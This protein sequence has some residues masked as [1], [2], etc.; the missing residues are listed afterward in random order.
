MQTIAIAILKF[1]TMLFKKGLTYNF[2]N[3]AHS[4]LSSFVILDRG[5]TVGTHPLTSRFMKGVYTLRP[6]IPRY[7][8]TWDV[9]IVFDYL[10]KLAPADSLNLKNLTLKLV[11]LIALVSAQ[12]SQSIHKLSLD[13]MYYKG[14]TTNFQIT[15][16]IKQSKPGMGGLTV[17]LPAYPVDRRLCVLTYLKHYINRTRKLQGKDA[18]LFISF[19]K[20]HRPVS[21]DISRWINLVMKDSGV[22]VTCFKPHSTRAAAT[23][24]ADKL[25]VPISLIL[26]TAGWSNERTF[27][28]Y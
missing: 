15:S 7:E 11:M 24:A 1:L 20:P 19:K 8:Y 21:K 4:S 14:S 16:L 28:Q 9:H 27:R 5:N 3:V 25:G 10:C 18:Q 13:N 2:L 22:D 23:S 12:R 6:P 17:K 26:Q